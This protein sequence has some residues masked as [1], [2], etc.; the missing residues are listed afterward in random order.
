ML[1][2]FFLQASVHLARAE[3]PLYVEYNAILLAKLTK[4]LHAQLQEVAMGNSDNDGAVLVLV[5]RLGQMH[6]VLVS[7]IVGVGP[8]IEN[9]DVRILSLKFFTDVDHLGVAHI[10]TVLFEREA[11][12]QN[13]RINDVNPPLDYH[14][15]HTVGNIAADGIVDASTFSGLAR[16]FSEKGYGRPIVG[17]RLTSSPI[18][19]VIARQLC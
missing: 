11:Q 13:I 9:I 10:R 15:D 7:D 17:F 8:W 18:L 16:R 1:P 5:R 19:A 3:K 4:S 14:L 6:P 12:D 2:R